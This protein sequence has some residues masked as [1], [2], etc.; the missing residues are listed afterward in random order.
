MVRALTDLFDK[1]RR[2][3]SESQTRVSFSYLEVYNELIRDLLTPSEHYLDL[4]EDPIKGMVC[5]PRR[6]GCLTAHCDWA[7]RAPDC[8]GHLRV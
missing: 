7:W 5:C 3:Q 8:S 4:R 2:S 1:V 6:G